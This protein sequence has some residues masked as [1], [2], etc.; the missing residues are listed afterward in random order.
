VAD[1]FYQA[2]CNG[3]YWLFAFRTS[4]GLSPF[5]WLFCRRSIFVFRGFTLGENLDVNKLVACRDKGSWCFFLAKVK[6]FLTRFSKTGRKA[7]EVAVAGNDTKS[8]HTA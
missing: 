4:I 7:R 5:S 2:S 1:Q 6:Y 8:I 3:T